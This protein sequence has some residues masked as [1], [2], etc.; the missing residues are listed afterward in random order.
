V[1][2][3]WR[4]SGFIEGAGPLWLQRL[5]GERAP[6]H[7]TSIVCR[8]ATVTDADLTELRW[9]PEL[10]RLEL[11]NAPGITDRGLQEIAALSTLEHLA[12]LSPKITDRGVARLGA[13]TKLRSLW[14]PGHINEDAIRALRN[15]VN[16]ETLVYATP[17]PAQ[18]RVFDALFEKTEADF[19]QQPLAD[20]VDYLHER[21]EISIETVELMRAKPPRSAS[22]TCQL[23]GVSLARA[24]KESLEPLG[25]VFRIGPDRL[26]IT[27]REALAP[28][29][30]RLDELRRSF[31]KL[32]DLIVDWDVPPV[33][34]TGAIGSE[35]DRALDTL[36]RLGATICIEKPG[37]L[38]SVDLRGTDASDEA[39]RAV[40]RFK[41]LTRLDLQRTPI[42][43]EGLSL[44]GGL[45]RLELLNLDETAVDDDG[46]ER[47][48][49]LPAL[50]WL[51]VVRTKVTTAA[52]ARLQ[53]RMPNLM[54]RDASLNTHGPLRARTP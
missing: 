51:D 54:I 35:K 11:R 10:R 7:I 20:V 44:L 50:R 34:F 41:E 25:L 46:I 53:Q 4:V 30:P 1:T 52:I 47:L 17:T 28:V 3:K 18:E 24:L 45:D 31:P 22:I 32:A 39:L 2:E 38:R 8:D 48:P 19:S 12:V 37:L 21:H 27:T 15:L 5:L 26:V 33:Q 42:S 13:L 14:L 49:D 6:Q 23:R 29:Q 43:N 9:L 16:L 36:V 40:A